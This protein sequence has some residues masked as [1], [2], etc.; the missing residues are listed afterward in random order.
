MDRI[1]Q[2]RAIVRRVIQEYADFGKPSYGEVEVETVFDEATDHY[3]LLYTGWDEWRRIHGAVIHVDLR[4]GK[5]WIQHDGT[6]DGIARDF[7]KAGIP[8]EDIV[9]G[10]QHPFKRKFTEYAVG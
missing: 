6:E 10:F 8:K 4:E 7:V 5:V 3:E 2:Y 1:E 9:L